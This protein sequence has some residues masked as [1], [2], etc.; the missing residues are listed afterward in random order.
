MSG[1]ALK[2]TAYLGERDR[3]GGAILAD[4]LVD[5]LARRRV[6]AS[7]VLRGAEGFGPAKVL[8]TD[9]LLTLSD[10]LPVV[11]VAVDAPERITAALGDVAALGGDGLLTLERARWAGLGERP[12][13]GL[14]A[15]GEEAKLTLWLER[16]ARAGRSA[17]DVA[18]VEVLRR[19]GVD[20]ATVLLGV[21]G[22][23][24]GER[25][26]AR[27]RGGNS[28]VP[29]LVLAVGAGEC[30]AA[31]SADLAALLG[32]V[33]ATLERVRVCRRDGAAL[34]APREIPATD[35]AGLGLWQKLTVFAGVHDR[36][37][38]APLHETLVRTLRRRG[39][40]GATTLRGTWGYHGDHAPHGDRLL[41]LRRRVPAMTV[42]VDTPERT[43]CWFALAERV[44][45]ERG[46]VT[47]EIVPAARIAAGGHTAGGLRLAA[48]VG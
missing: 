36:V 45:A 43:R 35:A 7:I 1:P 10:D 31:A 3:A 30:L 39:A 26:R 20:G 11:V 2:L 5:C 8:R 25:R 18:A 13:H 40:A 48:R 41:A 6:A 14:D 37:D 33:P 29:R 46:L 38:G 19:H 15:P 42:V 44:T 21:D 9:R 4:A 23:L 27:L 24:A 12:E 47:S 32:P 34:A 28:G 17:G 22:T 16:G